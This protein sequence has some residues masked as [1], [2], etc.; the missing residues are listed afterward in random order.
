MKMGETKSRVDVVLHRRQDADMHK[1]ASARF[2]PTQ[3]ASSE[4]P[5]FSGILDRK[6]QAGPYR[7]NP[8]TVLPIHPRRPL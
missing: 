2:K 1:R 6:E 7:S 8:L 4:R 5:S 3:M